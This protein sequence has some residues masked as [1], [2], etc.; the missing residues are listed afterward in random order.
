[1]SPATKDNKKHY[2]QIGL[3]PETYEKFAKKKAE[4]EKEMGIHLSWNDFVL[5]T[6]K[7]MDEAANGKKK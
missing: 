6:L 5:L 3:V 1:M 4:R 7:D 2:S